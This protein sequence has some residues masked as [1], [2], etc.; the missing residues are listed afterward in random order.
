MAV[1]LF[2]ISEQ[3]EVA[4]P[5]DYK[6]LPEH[7]RPKPHT[8]EE[9]GLIMSRAMSNLIK[10]SEI[11]FKVSENDYI[12]HLNNAV[13]GIKASIMKDLKTVI[14]LVLPAQPLQPLELIPALRDTLGEDESAPTIRWINV[15]LDAE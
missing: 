15:Y 4:E 9:L 7:E 8:Y 10:G 5:G 6:D 12:H 13:Q 1:S 11:R 2:P 3:F 14:D